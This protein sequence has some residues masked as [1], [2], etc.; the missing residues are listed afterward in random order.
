MLWP[1]VIQALRTPQRIAIVDDQRRYSYAQLLGG[2]MFMAEQ[3]E[4]AS[5]K[6]HIGIL[7]P[8]GGLFPMA[9]LG[10]WFAK[11]V[12]VPLNY[13]LKSDELSYVIQD[14]GVDTV[15]TVGPLLKMVQ[16]AA[17]RTPAI[18]ESIHVI[19]MEDLDFSGLPP[20]RW[21]PV[22]KRDDLA[23]ILYTSGTSG[24]PKGVMLSQ[25]NFRSNVDA[26][27]E[28]SKITRF[29]TFLGVL[30]QFHSFGLT[31][32][33]LIPL[34]IGA[35]VVY[36]ARF[37]PKQIIRLMRQHR[38]QIFMAIPSMYAAL[39]TV[40]SAEPGDFE[41]IRMAISGGEPLPGPTFEA[42]LDKFHLR[43]LEGYGLTETSPATNWCTPTHHRR[44]S[45]GPAL[46]GVDI[47]IIDDHGQMLATNEDGEI[48][49]A[50][51]NVMKGY[52][53]LPKET[54]EV[55]TELP[56]PVQ[57]D[58][59]G[60]LRHRYFRTGDIGHLDDDGFLYITGRKKEMLIVGGENVFPR[61]IEDVLNRHETVRESAVI[62]QSDEVRG[63]V[64]IAF[65]E[66][67][68]DCEFDAGR[69]RLWCREHLAGHK[70]P[71]Q[72][73]RIAELPRN[74]TGKVLRR[75]LLER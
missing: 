52:Y 70:V 54:A 56:V 48:V 34:R 40:K 45:V 66:I 13:L 14:S 71:R 3:I 11:R 28:H 63:E 60:R 72:I 33:T 69:L 23:V 62:G 58:A 17:G 64:P 59:N 35:T 75:Q 7:L 21:P 31:A 44:R 46:P 16:N 74:P 10:A 9:L 37:I 47:R 18:P 26:A 57:L 50:G 5:A 29:D 73:K 51:P 53:R 61:E 15:I 67:L 25:G 38:P 32:L 41:S 43:I 8:T 42:C 24:R 20:L 39:L 49:V 65:V 12:A 6:A 4:A 68:E 36:T 22:S 55:F 27:I 2:A 30:P 19:C 1:I